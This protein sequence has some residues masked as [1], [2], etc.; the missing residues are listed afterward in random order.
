MSPAGSLIVGIGSAHG[1]D[2]AGWRL[3]DELTAKETTGAELRKASVPHD[4]IEWMNHIQS[5]HIADACDSHT[6]VQRLD[7]SNGDLAC[8]RNADSRSSHQLGLSHVIGL[9][10]S[11]GRLPKQVV[12]W[13]IPGERFQPNGELSDACINQIRRCADRIHHELASGEL[14]HA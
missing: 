2:Q 8:S 7:L 12:L 11:L 10:D 6:D 13:A 4:M 3:I 5:L 1:D 9:I 14:D